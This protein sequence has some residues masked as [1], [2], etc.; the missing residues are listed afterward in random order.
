[1]VRPESVDTDTDLLSCAYCGSSV[2]VGKKHPVYTDES[3][4]GDVKLY[5]FCDGEC[6]EAW[7]S[8]R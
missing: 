8:E 1:M 2:S 6:I 7:L 5:T 4:D 3:D